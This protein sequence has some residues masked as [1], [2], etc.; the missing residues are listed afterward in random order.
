[1]MKHAALVLALT[2][3]AVGEEL[4]D[5]DDTT[6]AGGG[7][8]F[9]V[10]AGVGGT[11]TTL[12]TYGGGGVHPGANAIDIGAG[13]GLAVFHQLDYLPS[14]IAGGWVYVQEAHEAGLCSAFYPGHPS[15]NGAKIYVWTYFYDTAGNFVGS[16][17]AAYQHVDPH[18]PNMNS[19]WTWNNAGADVPAWGHGGHLQYGG[20]TENGLFIG[21]VFSVARAIYNTNGGLC[22]TGSHLHQENDGARAA[23]RY[24]AERN[25]GRYSDLHFFYPRGGMSAGA[26][27]HAPVPGT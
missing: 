16:N 25:T 21:T 10:L 15:Y 6:R 27:P 17:R 22:T 4:P 8:A 18:A 7:G 19:W 5:D 14:Y 13:G 24:G 20:T 23:K 9:A 11:I 2:A 26:P 3:C 12:A 1:M